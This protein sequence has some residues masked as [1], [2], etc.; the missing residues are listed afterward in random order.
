MASSTLSYSQRAT[1]RPRNHLVSLLPEA[2]FQRLAPDLKTI[3]AKV[4]DVFHHRGQ[5]IE[6]VYFMNAG[7]ASITT[8]LSN[9]AMVETAT[10]GDEGMLGV[11]AILGANAISQGE[12]MMQVPASEGEGTAEMLT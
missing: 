2:D 1:A 10:V 11:E 8:L 12:T 7:V 4:K 3:S 6:H 5:P 9:G